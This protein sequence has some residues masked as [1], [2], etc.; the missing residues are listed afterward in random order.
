M[1]F[2]SISSPK[3]EVWSSTLAYRAKL[4]NTLPT[5]SPWLR[6]IPIGID[7]SN[8]NTGLWTNLQLFPSKLGR[9]RWSK[10]GMLPLD[11]KCTSFHGW[12]M[13]QNCCSNF[14]TLLIHFSRG[15]PNWKRNVG[16]F[17]TDVFKKNL[18]FQTTVDEFILGSVPYIYHI[19]PV[20]LILNISYNILIYYI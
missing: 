19:G 11:P 1:G 9:R 16:Q 8:R 5:G 13:Q 3:F 6:S 20:A 2:K 17:K 7:P 10:S 4:T 14:Q 12:K 18:I 15:S